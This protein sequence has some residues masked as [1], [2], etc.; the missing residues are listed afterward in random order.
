MSILPV[1]GK[2]RK[3]CKD[4]TED[5]TVDTPLKTPPLLKTHHT[6][7]YF[8]R[9][10]M[11]SFSLYMYQLVGRQS[12][13]RAAGKRQPVPANQRENSAYLVGRRQSG[14]IVAAAHWME[15][16]A[17]WGLG[18]GRSL[19]D[20]RVQSL[21]YNM[22]R[23]CCRVVWKEVLE[24]RV[25]WQR[26]NSSWARAVRRTTA[27]SWVTKVMNRHLNGHTV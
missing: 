6:N 15:V 4:T 26:P 18:Y 5:T 10:T 12:T 23:R 24:G 20:A 27:C 14:R 22:I 17:C 25:P 1:L 11:A 2:M 16:R 8:R 7:H 19:E 13:R 9:G 3:N 21:Q